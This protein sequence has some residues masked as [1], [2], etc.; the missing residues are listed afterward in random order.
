M[1]EGALQN[2]YITD[3]KDKYFYLLKKCIIAMFKE[4]IDLYDEDSLFDKFLF[5]LFYFE[6]TGLIN[7]S[8]LFGDDKLSNLNKEYN[9]IHSWF[10]QLDIKKQFIETYDFIKVLFINFFYIAFKREYGTTDAEINC[11]KNARATLA[12]MLSR[13]YGLSFM[14]FL[15]KDGNYLSH[16]KFLN[17]FNSIYTTEDSEERFNIT[18]KYMYNLIRIFI[19]KF[20]KQR[21]YSKYTKNEYDFLNIDSSKIKIIINDVLM[22]NLFKKDKN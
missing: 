17:V 14:G 13:L 1:Y 6:E 8:T 16:D 11:V 15:L 4:E 22:C 3:P 12:F 5:E 9:I 19:V 10:R 7:Y 2:G 21:L 20:K 18:K